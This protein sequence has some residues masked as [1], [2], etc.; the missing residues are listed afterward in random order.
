[1]LE[2]NKI[3]IVS[4]ENKKDKPVKIVFEG[5]LC[6]KLLLFGKE[7]RCE[8]AKFVET[9]DCIFTLKCTAEKCE[10]EYVHVI[11]SDGKAEF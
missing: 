5:Q 10:N 9:E 2:D 7:Y 8:H 6:P 4:T 3:F 1:M 11:L